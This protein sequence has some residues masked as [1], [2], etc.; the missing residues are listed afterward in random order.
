MPLRM[1]AGEFGLGLGEK[2]VGTAL[3]VCRLR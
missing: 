2:F 3:V 1:H